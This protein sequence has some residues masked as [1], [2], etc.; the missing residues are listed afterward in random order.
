MFEEEKY[1]IHNWRAKEI[2]R[3]LPTSSHMRPVIYYRKSF[4]FSFLLL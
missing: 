2:V 1:K 4:H 3:M